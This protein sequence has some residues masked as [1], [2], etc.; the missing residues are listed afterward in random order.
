[1]M[2]LA[3]DDGDAALLVRLGHQMLYPQHVGTGGV[4][5]YRPDLRQPLQHLLALAVG[6]DDDRISRPH[7]LRA[8]DGAAAQFFQLTHHMGVVDNAAQHHAAALFTGRFLCQRYGA[9][10]AV[11]ETGALRLNDP[12]RTPPSSYTWRMTS[13]TFC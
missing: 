6:P 8:A 10:H 5:A 11:A 3:N 7:F 4:D 2:L 13:S 1:M 9:L 12:H